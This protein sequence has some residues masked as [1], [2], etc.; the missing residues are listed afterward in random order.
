MRDVEHSKWIQSQLRAQKVTFRDIAK[1]LG[2]HHLEVKAVC[3]RRYRSPSI[4]LAVAEKLRLPANSLW[5]PL[6]Q[7][8]A[9]QTAR[10][11]IGEP[12][13]RRYRR[14]VIKLEQSTKQAS[15]A[16]IG[17]EYPPLPEP[18]AGAGKTPEPSLDI[19]PEDCRPAQVDPSISFGEYEPAQAEAADQITLSEQSPD[20]LVEAYQPAQ[21]DIE[22]HDAIKRRLRARKITFV[23]IA[24]DL[25]I[26][27]PAVTRVC[28]G[29]ARSIRVESYIAA[30]LDV[31]ISSLWPGR[32]DTPRP[33][34]FIPSPR[35]E[36]RHNEIKCRMRAVGTDFLTLGRDL[37]VSEDQVWAVS[38]G[39]HR[40]KRVEEAIAAA[41]G[42]PVTTLWPDRC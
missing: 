14:P 27:Q 16:A 33:R 28:Q 37:G 18:S 6:P 29:Y 24:K 35:D 23:K 25:G 8:L 4:E 1:E 20:T 12:K 3:E 42:V 36:D 17:Q 5:P 41:L 11:L 26:T 9:V 34:A 2:I 32:S 40:S 19:S 31:S 7:H 10:Q 22:N 30:A 39:N 38:H 13:C 21:V 15:S